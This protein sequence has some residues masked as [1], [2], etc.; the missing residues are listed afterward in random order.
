MKKFSAL[1][2]FLLFCAALYA[3]SDGAWLIPRTIYVGDPAVMV[4][5]LPA[6]AHDFPDTV[7][8]AQEYDILHGNYL[9]QDDDIDFHRIALERRTSGSRLVIE[10]A[11]FVPGILE[12]PPIEIGDMLFDGLTVTVHSIVDSKNHAPGRAMELS[13]PASSLAMPGT[14]VMLYGTMTGFVLLFLFTFWFILK[15]RRY[16]QKWIEKW[17]LYRIFVSV[18]NMERRLHRAV[19]KGINK[20]DILDKLSDEFRTFLSLLTGCN[21]RAMTA[22]E[23]EKLPPEFIPGQGR[24]SRFLGNFF[25]RCD[26]FRFSGANVSSEDIFI[27]LADLRF[28]IGELE[29]NKKE[30]NI[31]EEEKAA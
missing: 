7:I 17:K 20:R 14:A 25:S 12:L 13:R 1:A 26:K 8:S 16:L 4:L 24:D 31:T 23:F 6:S 28:Y 21:C 18:K 3:Q 29:K 22:R 27:L 5:P 15:G 2:L 30:E 11:A 9:P 10:F 19:L